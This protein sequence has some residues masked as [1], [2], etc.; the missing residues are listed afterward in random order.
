MI[1]NNINGKFYIGQS[2]NIF[3]RWSKHI[4]EA[5]E[6]PYDNSILHK[7][8]RKYNISCF[9]FKILEL[10]DES[11]LNE[12][13]RFYID[14]YEA[15]KD[16]YNILDGGSG[17]IH[18]GSKNH[19]SKLKE[20]DVYN[21]REQYKDLKTWKEVYEKYKNII[22]KNTFKDVWIGKTWKH[23]HMDVYNDEIKLKQRNNYDK[24]QSH[25]WMQ[26]LSNEDIIKIRT[27]KKDGFKPKYVYENYYKHINRNTFND[28]WYYH[29][30]KYIIL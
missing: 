11:K 16:N 23:I 3:G 28:V 5:F 4:R 27:F 15:T 24:I 19:N 21:I 17:C 12:M 18:K 6:K 2:R 29:T 9:Q 13:E 8:I 14:L 22:S 10:C 20:E 25:K 26:K 30:F 1:T 7:A